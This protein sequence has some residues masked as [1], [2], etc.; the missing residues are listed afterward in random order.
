MSLDA[1][2]RFLLGALRPS[3][4]PEAERRRLENLAP[5][6]DG[7]ALAVRAA[8]TNASPLI[9]AHLEASGALGWIAPG[10]AR[11]LQK[12]RQAVWARNLFLF[13][14]LAAMAAR[15]NE[16]GLDAVLLK[17]SAWSHYG[18]DGLMRLRVM[19][20]IDMLVPPGRM[21]DFVACLEGLGFTNNK[22]DQKEAYA[23]S[24]L[25]HPPLLSPM[26]FPYELHYNILV[27][28][29]VDLERLWERSTP[30]L[31]PGT[32]VLAWEDHLYYQILHVHH[33]HFEPNAIVKLLSDWAYALGGEA[34]KP[35][36]RAMADMAGAEGAL[37]DL[38]EAMTVVVE[39][40]RE[41]LPL[42]ALEE[43]AKELLQ[44]ARPRRLHPAD[45]YLTDET[46]VATRRRLDEMGEAWQRS[47]LPQ[48]LGML[49]RKVFP[50]P[51]DL[52]FYYRLDSFWP[53]GPLLYL[54]RPPVLAWK[55]LRHLRRDRQLGGAP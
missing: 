4:W 43:G 18:F 22:R 26:Q 5:L 14:E 13:R 35:D 2:W 1:T 9:H 47:G 17:G 44:G 42:Q 54:L 27:H 3:P 50:A 36:W 32:R 25:Q 24:D 28:Q 49:A 15:W 23:F 55:A 33:H 40:S 37:G 8:H 53:W 19:S 39:L 29:Q 30:G 20:D 16:A 46:W 51:A 7:E 45:R 10:T 48:R 6:V 52:K 38:R 11:R 12:T 31:W 34:R 21:D 41:A